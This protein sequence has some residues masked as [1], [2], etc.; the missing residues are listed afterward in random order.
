MTGLEFCAVQSAAAVQCKHSE[1]LLVQA[2]LNRDTEHSYCVVSSYVYP[3][4]QIVARSQKIFVCVSA[5]SGTECWNVAQGSLGHKYSATYCTQP[6]AVSSTCMQPES[7][8]GGEYWRE[9]K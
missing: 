8:D 2:K 6:L 5:I 1:I 9:G 3:H 7:C 4:I